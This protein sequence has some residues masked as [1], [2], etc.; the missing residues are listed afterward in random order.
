MDL[1]I[2]ATENFTGNSARAPSGRS[3]LSKNSPRL[4]HESLAN[5]LLF[6]F[7]VL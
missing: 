1:Q 7:H 4:D 3:L 2:C 6:Y 5:E